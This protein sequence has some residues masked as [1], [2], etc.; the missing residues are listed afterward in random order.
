MGGKQASTPHLKCGFHFSS[1]FPSHSHSQILDKLD[2]GLSISF[3]FILQLTLSAM[4]LPLDGVHVEH[5]H[6]VLHRAAVPGARVG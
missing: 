2:A 6:A 1:H 4:L 3:N 5:V